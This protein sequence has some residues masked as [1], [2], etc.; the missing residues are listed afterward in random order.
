[1]RCTQAGRSYWG[2][3]KISIFQYDG[4]LTSAC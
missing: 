3:R 4:K 2:Y 1:L